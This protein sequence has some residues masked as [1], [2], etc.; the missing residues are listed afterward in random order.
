MSTNQINQQPFQCTV[1]PGVPD[2]LAELNI[3]LVVT[4]YQANALIVLSPFEGGLIQLLRRFQKPMGIAVD[5]RDGISRRLAV[6]TQ[7][8]VILLK[9]DPRLGDLGPN[10]GSYDAMFAPRGLFFVNEVFIHDMAWIGGE[11][12]TVNTLFS[13]LSTL[14]TEFSFVPKWQ[15]PFISELAPEDR[16]HLNGLAAVDGE[17]VWV[18]ALGSTDTAIGWRENR[19]N[20]GVLINVP[21]N[22]VVITNLPMPHSPRVYDGEL[23]FLISLTGELVRADTD[24]GTYERVAQLP[25][26]VRG[27]SRCGDYLFVGMSK[28]RPGRSMG[29]LPIDPDRLKPGLGI[30]HLPTGNVTGMISYETDCEEIYDVQVLSGMRRPG[31]I[32]LEGDAFRSA[33]STPERSFWGKPPEER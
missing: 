24:R 15:P 31:V 28:L 30:V 17:P 25:G 4:T 23:F 14:D 8:E 27:L 16:C 18:T 22:E 10:A 33:L 9:N 26:Y 12:W 20:G 6:A 7:H 2:L 3:S 13:C 5:D 21:E 11:L 32:G 29:N 19:V 1:T